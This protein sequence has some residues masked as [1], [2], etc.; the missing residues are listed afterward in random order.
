MYATTSVHEPW[1]PPVLPFRLVSKDGVRWS[2]SPA[3]PLLQPVPPYDSIET[4]SVVHFNG[5][6][7]MFFTGIRSNPDPSPM[8]IGHAVSD[9]GIR[10]TIDRP[11]LVQATGVA[12]DWRSYLV[13]E[14][15]AVVVGDRLLVY[16]SAV[17]ARK[18]D[19]PP[20]DQS[21]GVI[22]STDGTNFEPPRRVLPQGA[23]YSAAKG[24]AGYSSP[25]AAVIDGRVHLFYSVAHYDRGADPEWRQVA[26][27]HATS[28]DG[29]SGFVE[30]AQPILALT[31]ASWTGGE[32][33]GPSP[34]VDGG[35]L[36]LWFGAHVA[37]ADL[38]PL[39]KR[40]FHGAEFGIGEASID[41]DRF[42]G[43]AAANQESGGQR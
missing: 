22:A 41:L 39:I 19:G 35:K 4:P 1:H 38:G 26:I 33:I 25:A 16:F 31:S 8:S 28:F 11:V 37:N 42:G 17:G 7:H 40:G 9:D 29:L 3:A 12:D 36:R 27:N 21:I 43:S 18:G 30:D 15:G 5:R 10:W 6:W 34:L 20:Q 24:Y 2:L 32:V 14:P 13:A 23:A